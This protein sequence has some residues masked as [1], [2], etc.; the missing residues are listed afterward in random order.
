M[1]SPALV[2]RLVEEWRAR[3]RARAFV[4]ADLD[5]IESMAA[6]RALTAEHL[7]RFTEEQASAEVDRD[8]LHAFGVL[9]RILGRRG[10]SPTLAAAVID[11]ARHAL[12]ALETLPTTKQALGPDAAWVAPARAALAEAF[13]AS[14]EEATRAEAAAR[15]EYPACI[16]GLQD[17]IVA[18]AAGYPEED[19]EALAAW[20]SRI[21]HEAALAGVRRAVVSGSRAAEAALADALQV[22][23]IQPIAAYPIGGGRQPSFAGRE[24]TKD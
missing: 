20:A 24:A 21:A 4:K 2:D 16:V 6:V 14:R 18:V 19:A 22:A 13:V 17:A 8:L 12:G 15:W 5:V 10:A 3:D 11:D 23:G 7:L 1:A 9:G